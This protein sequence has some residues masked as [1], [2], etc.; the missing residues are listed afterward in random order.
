MEKILLNVSPSIF[1]VTVTAL[2][3]NGYKFDI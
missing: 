2:W 3:Y 1:L